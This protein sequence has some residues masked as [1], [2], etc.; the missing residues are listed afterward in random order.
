MNTLLTIN[1]VAGRFAVGMKGR[2]LLYRSTRLA[3]IVTIGNIERVFIGQRS[4]NARPRAHVDTHL[5]AH[6]SSERI[7]RE[8]NMPMKA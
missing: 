2:S 1:T 5:L 8:V 4:L 6:P 3:P 7:G